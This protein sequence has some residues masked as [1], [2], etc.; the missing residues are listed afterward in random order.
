MR[1]KLLSSSV[2]P[3]YDIIYENL[4]KTDAVL[5][6]KITRR[7][8]QVFC[9]APQ[10]KKNNGD[11]SLSPTKKDDK[12]AVKVATPI[13]EKVIY[14][15]NLIGESTILSLEKF[16]ELMQCIPEMFKDYECK[17]VYINTKHGTSI[18]Q[19]MRKARDHAP[20]LLI[21]KDEFGFI[22]GAYGNESLRDISMADHFYGSGECFL[23]TFRDTNEVIPYYWTKKNDYYMLTDH[24]GIYFGAGEHYGL[25][26][27]NDMMRG[28]SFRSDT[29]DNDPLSFATDFE[30]MKVEVWS[31]QDPYSY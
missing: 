9:N 12:K 2:I 22:F 6:T 15:P 29:Y 10:V 31:I 26:I 17:P 27:S 8:H 25:W 1:K 21:V 24:E 23:F 19:L 5:L 18:S 16:T 30:I 14:K 3:Y 13:K 4:S 11:N 28:R 7:Q 20:F